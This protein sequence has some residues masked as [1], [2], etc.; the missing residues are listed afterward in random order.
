M[1][2]VTIRRRGSQSAAEH[3]EGKSLSA[4]ALEV[5]PLSLDEALDRCVVAR[6]IGPRVIK[7]RTG[8][9]ISDTVLKRLVPAIFL[10]RAADLQF[11]K[12][13][14]KNLTV[15]LNA[16][17]DSLLSERVDRLAVI[18]S[19]LPQFQLPTFSLNSPTPI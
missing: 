13:S 7:R 5:V 8:N 1:S 11:P 12:D 15:D 9:L 16:A 19:M 17:L 3:K 2:E 14:T 18:S 10:A 4:Y 6:G